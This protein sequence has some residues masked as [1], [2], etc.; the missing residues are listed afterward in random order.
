MANRRACSASVAQFGAN[1][2]T[3]SG[4]GLV[5]SPRA[6]AIAAPDSQSVDRQE[7]RLDRFI[8]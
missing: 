5:S 4:Q 7:L 1:A 2:Y 6:I 8:E 3:L